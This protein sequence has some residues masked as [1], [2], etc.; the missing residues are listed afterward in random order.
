MNQQP[1]QTNTLEQ[2]NIFD[3]LG[4]SDASQEDQ[5]AMLAEFQDA[6]WME[7]VE[8]DEYAKKIGDDD[9]DAFEKIIDNT[10]L[11][12]EQKRNEMFNFLASRI[13]NLEIVLR[14]KTN[15][16]KLELLA[17][18]V[19]GM[20]EFFANQPDKQAQVEQAGALI[21]AGDYS[22]AI[23]QLNVLADSIPQQQ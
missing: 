21:E 20:S 19:Q 23:Q 3:L 13:D 10:A 16:L 8:S 5:T 6:I 1:T 4:V 18:R 14:E 9:L 2:V 22:T 11:D 15:I 7:I 12:I 17:A